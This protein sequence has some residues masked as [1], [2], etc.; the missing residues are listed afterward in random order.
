MHSFIVFD[1]AFPFDDPFRG[2]VEFVILMVTGVF[3][4]SVLALGIGYILIFY[5]YSYKKENQHNLNAKGIQMDQF[6]KISIW[7]SRTLQRLHIFFGFSIFFFRA[8]YGKKRKSVFFLTLRL[9][10]HCQFDY[11]LSNGICLFRMK[12]WS[13]RSMIFR[14]LHMYMYMKLVLCNMQIYIEQDAVRFICHLLPNDRLIP[15]S[16]TWRWIF[17]STFFLMQ[18]K[19]KRNHF[20]FGGRIRKWIYHQHSGKEFFRL[21]S[22]SAWLPGI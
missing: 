2:I 6:G 4:A 19:K 22:L 13:T 5:V 1:A 11:Y 17:G 20:P 18:T 15:L 7:K 16:N 3:W 9:R 14:S 21:F 12:S 10:S 8:I